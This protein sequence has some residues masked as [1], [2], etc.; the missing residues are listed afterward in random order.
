MTSLICG[1]QKVIQVNLFTIQKQIHRLQK[2]TYGY[3][4]EKNGRRL[5]SACA[6]GHPAEMLRA[7]VSL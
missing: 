3:Q 7:A 5:L 2:Q 1:I 6:L 4:S